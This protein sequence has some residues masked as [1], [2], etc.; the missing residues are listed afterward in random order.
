M[1]FQ[2]SSKG[3]EGKSQPPQSGWKIVPQSRTGC[4]ETPVAKCVVWHWVYTTGNPLSLLE[5]FPLG[6]PE[7]ILEICS[8]VF[9]RCSTFVYWITGGKHLT[10]NQDRYDLVVSNTA[11]TAVKW[12]FADSEKNSANALKWKYIL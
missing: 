6:C 9:K 1:C 10:S 7:N 3:I 12:V 8:L 2:R 5:F 4:R 11:N